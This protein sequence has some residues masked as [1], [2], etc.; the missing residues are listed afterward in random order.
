MAV[1]AAADEPRHGPGEEGAA[2][3]GSGEEPEEEVGS[4]IF[5]F[6]G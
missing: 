1:A 5:V 2:A 6:R 3:G 4:S